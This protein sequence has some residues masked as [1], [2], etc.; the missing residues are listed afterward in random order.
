MGWRHIYNPQL[1]V[2][3]FEQETPS[4]RAI[5]DRARNLEGFGS[6]LVRNCFNIT[7][8]VLS[9]LV[10]FKAPSQDQPH[11]EQQGDKRDECTE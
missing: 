7:S 4:C 9:T 3:L 8:R 2:S 6:F 1:K 11:A 10:K 5:R